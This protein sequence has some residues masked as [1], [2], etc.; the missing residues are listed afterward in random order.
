[1]TTSTLQALDLSVSLTA[2]DLTES[3]TFYEGLGFEVTERMEAEGKLLG[4]M[5][6][7]GD[8]TLGLS[9]DDFTKGKKRVKGIG[10][11]LYLVTDQDL[12]PLAEQIKKAG[13]VFEVPLAPLAW[14]PMGFTVRDPDGFRVTVANPEE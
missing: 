11:G 1:M 9:Q 2:N 13:I 14:G 10:M 6:E 5:I 7:A 3:I 12:E 8:V 4:V